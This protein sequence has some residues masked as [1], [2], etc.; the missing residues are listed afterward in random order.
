MKKHLLIL[1]MSSLFVLG[2]C[3]G[4]NTPASSPTI[5]SAGTS[6]ATISSETL[7]EFTGLA[8]TDQ[9]VVYDGAKHSLAVQNVP[10]GATVTYSGQD[11]INAGTYPIDATVAKEGYA[12]K[13]LRATL[14]ITEADLTAEKVATMGLSLKDASYP[15]DGESH[16]LQLTGDVPSG[17]S[18]SYTIDG[19]AG[20]SA[21]DVGEHVVVATLK[22]PNYHAFTLTAKLSIVAVEKTLY[23]TVVGTTILFQNDLDNDSLYSYE[24]SL[25][26][27]SYDVMGGFSG[28]GSLSFGIVKS[29]WGKAVVS[30]QKDSS[31]NLQKSKVLAGVSVDALAAVD[32]THFYYSVHNVLVNKEDNGLYYYDTS[33][34][35]DDYR[36]EK[37]ISNDYATAM[38]YSDGVLYYINSEKN[39]VSY[40]SG[41]KTIYLTDGNIYELTAKDG[42]LYYN[43]GS[44][45]GKGLYRMA[46]ASKQESKLTLDNGRDLSIIGNAL[47]YINKDVLA[48][49]LFGKGIYR[50]PLD[51]TLFNQSG[52]LVISGEND[53]I[54]SLTSDGTSLYYYRF[55]NSH[56]YQ[57]ATSGAAEVDLMV[58]FVKP[59]D[60]TLVGGAANAYANGQVYFA[61]L[62]DDG[63]LYKY[64]LTSKQA[65]KVLPY[66]VNNVYVN[67]NYLYFGSYVLTNYAE[68]RMD[69]TSKVISKISKDRCESLRFV[70]EKI[71]YINVGTTVATLHEMALDGTSDRELSSKGMDPFSLEVIDGKVYS[72][73]DPAVGYKKMA[74][75]DIATAT[76]SETSQ[77]C[78]SFVK[79][80]G[81]ELYLYNGADKTLA[82]YQTSSGASATLLSA[83]PELSDLAFAN[84]TL[85]AQNV[86]T[87]KLVAYQ[88]SAL[89]A[90]ADIAPSGI[91]GDGTSLYF[92][93]A[94]TSFVNNYPA[95]TY[96]KTTSNGALYSYSNTLACLAQF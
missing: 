22:M 86:G 72:V 35:D 53:K 43:K 75:T 31:G 61:N 54:G 12:S 70:G 89:T 60:T 38:V 18:V 36:G 17:T 34:G 1:A 20:N 8:F 59:E 39:I 48:T 5:S 83:I 24:T 71:Y 63:C 15:Y 82:N 41:T 13:T 56:F 74:V 45:A 95:T 33:K 62:K 66:S 27:V 55:N 84:G 87:K 49:S 25:K 19:A 88:N 32:A 52:T 85:Y 80:A 96:D 94:K 78:L 77:K 90:L 51:G 30:Y 64:D 14:T 44:V 6:P 76:M 81:S 10:S 46:I 58:D 57:N 3:T 37:I 9:S 16:T 42:Y 93:S 28:T 91:V 69:L 65:F 68:W 79:G 29:L 26:K 47:Y 11:Y 23:S 7:Q 40:A 92:V 4:G 50:V 21:V 73:R 2:A 67:G